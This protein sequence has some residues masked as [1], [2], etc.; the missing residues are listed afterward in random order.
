MALIGFGTE[1]FSPGPAKHLTLPSII[2]FGLSHSDGR[3]CKYSPAGARG[4]TGL[5]GHHADT[6][7]LHAGL[8]L[9]LVVVLVPGALASFIPARNASRLTVREVLAYE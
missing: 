2:V 8:W 1:C 5:D 6:F 9:W 3:Y 4:W 7:L